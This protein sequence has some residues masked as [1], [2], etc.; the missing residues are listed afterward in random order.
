MYIYLHIT[1]LK[2]IQKRRGTRK[3]F[4]PAR[5]NGVK[6]NRVNT[7][8]RVSRP[9]PATTGE[10]TRTHNIYT[11]GSIESEPNRR[12][13]VVWFIIIRFVRAVCSRRT[14]VTAVAVAVYAYRRPTWPASE[15]GPAHARHDNNI[16]QMVF[17]RKRFDSKTDFEYLWKPLETKCRNQNQIRFGFTILKRNIRRGLKISLFPKILCTQ[18]HR[19]WNPSVHTTRRQRYNVSRHRWKKTL[20]YRLIVENNA[21]ELNVSEFTR[22]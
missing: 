8:A 20:L 19:E 12:R 21:T 18:R 22:L 14:A 6:S 9:T 13:A 15:I 7:P 17:G 1:V 5:L 2:P 11:D 3:I 16:M 10:P 4:E